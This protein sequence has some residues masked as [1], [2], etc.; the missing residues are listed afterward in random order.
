MYTGMVVESAIKF[1]LS[2][3]DPKGFARQEKKREGL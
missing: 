1:Q 3:G 2:Y